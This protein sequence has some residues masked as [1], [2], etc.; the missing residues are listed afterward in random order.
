[1]IYPKHPCEVG[2]C[3]RLRIIKV[4]VLIRDSNHYN[5]KVRHNNNNLVNLH[6]IQKVLVSLLQF[7]LSDQ[8]LILN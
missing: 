8:S 4:F 1:L 7:S 2:I 5:N 3:R 6:K